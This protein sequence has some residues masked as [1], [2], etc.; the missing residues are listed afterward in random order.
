MTGSLA[1]RKN[2]AAIIRGNI[3][4][5][6]TRI[7]PHV[8]M[9]T[10]L[11]LGAA[12][13]VL[14]HLLARRGDSVVGLER[15]RERYESALRLRDAWGGGAEMVCGDI[16]NRLDLLAGVNTLLAV[17]MI[18]YLRDRLDEVFAEVAGNVPN[19]VLCGNKQRAAWWKAGVPDKA[20]G[21]M[22]YYASAEGM[23][24]VL[25]RHGYT[26]KTEVTKGDPIIVGS[27]G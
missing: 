5:K 20:G 9:G 2:E 15:S 6:Y 27:M 23:K 25:T 16:T 22:N 17:R 19:V 18:Y 13:G 11:E 10:I 12:E 3:P 1:Y 14:A 21:P 24:D 4:E 7:V 26:I 8:P